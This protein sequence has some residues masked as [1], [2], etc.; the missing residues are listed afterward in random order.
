MDKKIVK[1]V[2][3]LQLDKLF[4]YLV[5]GIIKYFII[6]FLIIYLTNVNS[7]N[8]LICGKIIDLYEQTHNPEY[9]KWLDFYVRV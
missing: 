6:I 8:P 1:I 2:Y 4:N 9:K 3:F 5:C 7:I